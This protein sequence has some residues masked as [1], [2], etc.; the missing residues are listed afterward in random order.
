MRKSFAGM[1]NFFFAPK[2]CAKVINE[3]SDTL[4]PND[5]YWIAG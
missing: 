3:K 4:P 1:K 5:D 2:T